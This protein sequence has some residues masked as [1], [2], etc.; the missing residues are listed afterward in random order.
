MQ[1]KLFSLKMKNARG[2]GPGDY[3]YSAKSAG[4]DAGSHCRQ[5]VRVFSEKAAPTAFLQNN[6]SL[7]KVFTVV[8]NSLHK[9]VL[10]L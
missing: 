9:N 7:R 1:N 2:E 8:L 5:L 6:S 10:S 3:V 4:E